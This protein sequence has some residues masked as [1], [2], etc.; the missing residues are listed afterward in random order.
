MKNPWDA[1]VENQKKTLEFW[2]NLSEQ[3]TTAP[4]AN[5]NGKKADAATDFFSQWAEQQKALWEQMTKTAANPQD[6]L[7]AMPEQFRQWTE[8]QQQFT[9]QYMTLYKENAL[10]MGLPTPQ[11]DMGAS[12]PGR[13]MEENLKN[14]KN[15]TQSGD[16]W[17]RDQMMGKLPFNMQPHYANFIEFFDDVHRYWE[18]FSRMIQNGIFDRDTV[19]K[20]FNRDAYLKVVNQLMGFKPVGNVTGLIDSVNAYFEKMTSHFGDDAAKW[21]TV[22]DT[23]RSKMADFYSGS[24]VP[25]LQFGND[26]NNRLRDQLTPFFNIAAQGRQTEIAKLMRDIQFAYISFI[27]KT[28][29][30]QSKVYDAGQFVLPDLLRKYYQEYQES[31]EMPDFQAF[32][33]KYINELEDQ[34]LTVLNADEYSKLQSE[35]A[36]LGVSIK[37]MNDKAGELVF[38]DMPFLTRSEGD[39]FAKEAAAMRK[40]VRTL[41]QRLEALESMLNNAQGDAAADTAAKA[42]RSTAKK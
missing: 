21:N 4:A 24:H 42:K 39:D 5:G 31:E 3:M 17:M 36:A 10:K 32:L 13:I 16:K 40:K 2:S 34:I 9:E 23:W 6:A 30:L 12:M 38:A 37:S 7:A 19:D 33:H 11:M 1:I 14:W 26:I 8:M 41:E 27:L 22:S 25:M 28:S 15:W 29:E 18:P 35:I 20:Y